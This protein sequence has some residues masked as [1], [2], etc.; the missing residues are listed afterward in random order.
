MNE[1]VRKIF[2]ESL[3]TILSPIVKFCIL[4]SIKYQ[5]FAETAKRIYVK[6]AQ[7]DIKLRELESSTSKLSVITGLR[8]REIDRLLN[9][10]E[11]LPSDGILILRLI[12]QWTGDKRFQNNRGKPKALELE[13]NDSEFASLVKTVSRDI[14]HRTLLFEL[15]RAGFIK[16]IGKKIHLVSSVYI[17]K[18]NLR[19]GFSLLSS[20]IRDLIAAG[21]ENIFSRAGPTNLHAKTVYDNVPLELESRIR[22]WFLIFGGKVHKEVRKYLS[23]Y[24]KDIN[25]QMAKKAGRMRVVLGTFSYIDP[26]YD[27]AVHSSSKVRRSR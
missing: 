21:N 16:R 23:Q 5:D 17:P 26:N 18:E 12:G 19:D 7:D 20:D 11:D 1:T 9:I 10:Q 4:R 13:G 2:L 24:D 25:K 6:A 8:R 3:S 15:E 22:E 27:K 14:N